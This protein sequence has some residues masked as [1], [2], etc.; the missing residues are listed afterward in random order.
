MPG[1]LHAAFADVV[2]RVLEVTDEDRQIVGH[3]ARDVGVQVEYRDHWHVGADDRADDLEQVAVGIVGAL[4][5]RRAVAG[6]EHAVERQHGFQAGGYF[7]QEVPEECRL[8]RTAGLR[9]GDPDRHRRPRPRGVHR[10]KEAGQVGKRDR[11]GGTALGDDAV[12]AD[13]DVV[14]EILRR[15]HRREAIALDGEAQHGD[16]G[17]VTG[18]EMPPQR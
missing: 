6:N 14:L 2:V 3:A 8:D 17:I 10:G 5:Q 4:G 16:P 11:G 9:L 13:V 7:G 1:G 18:Q 12:A 15:R